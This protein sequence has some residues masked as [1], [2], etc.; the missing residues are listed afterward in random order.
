M[1]RAAKTFLQRRLSS[2]FGKLEPTMPWTFD[3]IQREWFG[4]AC[5]DWDPD[6]VVRAFNLAESTRG[7]DWVLGREVDVAA[8]A[9]VPGIGRRGG[10]SEFLR[11]YWF[12]TRMAS[13]VGAPGCDDLVERLMAGDSAASE[14]ATAIHLLRS[15]HHDTELEIAPKVKIGNRHRVPDFRLR[16]A[17]EPWI[18]I[19]VTKL[20]ESTASIQIQRLLQRVAQA[21]MTVDQAFLLEIVFNRDPTPSEEEEV[22]TEAKAA[23]DAADGHR[24]NVG[25]L[26][27]ILVKSGDPSV[28]IPSLTP[29]DSRPRMAVSQSIIGDGQPNR[30]IV[31]RIPFEDQRAE[32]ILR[33][34][35]K[36]LPKDECGVVM[37]NVNSQPSAFESWSE[38]VPQRFTGNQHTRVAAVVLFMHA[39]SPTERG[40]VWV[41]YL[42]M[43]ANPR[44]RVPVPSWV[45][46]A[47]DRIRADT[48]RLTGRTD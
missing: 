47:V 46:D 3:E 39:T 43:I 25:D 21:V 15:R 37:V 28:V 22:L 1:I 30:Q 45:A 38:R 14:E 5:L 32:H 11:V 13:I 36:Q 33:I 2:L 26:A 19:E 23:C 4:N 44:A 31:A 10:Y 35:S 18:Y 16:K 48:R 8:F 9:G 12:G 6:D 20:H 29:D 34:K 27:S 17:G 42:K 7:R 24:K 41:P 40:L